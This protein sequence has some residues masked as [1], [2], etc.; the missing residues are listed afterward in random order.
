MPVLEVD[1]LGRHRFPEALEFNVATYFHDGR[2]DRGL[3]P[4]KRCPDMSSM[5]ASTQVLSPP[6]RFATDAARDVAQVSVLQVS[7]SV[8]TPASDMATDAWPIAA[9]FDNGA[10]GEQRRNRLPFQIMRRCRRRRRD[11]CRKL[12]HRHTESRGHGRSNQGGCGTSHELWS[13][14]VGHGT[15]QLLR[16]IRAED[17]WLLE[18]WSAWG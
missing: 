1:V 4:A 6:L 13:L 14:V 7:I 10:R 2:V 17:T 9:S 16:R 3:V 8:E 12:R 18:W 5:D 11:T 15:E